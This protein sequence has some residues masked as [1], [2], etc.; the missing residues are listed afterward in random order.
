MV[1]LCVPITF[2]TKKLE[3]AVHDFS[4]NGYMRQF[5][6]ITAL[7]AARLEIKRR[8]EA[9]KDGCGASGKSC[10]LPGPFEKKGCMQ[11][12]MGGFG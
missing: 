7:N 6:K 10:F 5:R 1:K 8:I 3:N 9:V 4:V 2:R 11:E 12:L